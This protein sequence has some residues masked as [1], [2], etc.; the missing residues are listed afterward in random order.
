M[1]DY[2]DP[3]PRHKSLMTFKRYMKQYKKSQDNE[4]SGFFLNK[5]GT[6]SIAHDTSNHRGNTNKKK[7]LKEGILDK[8]KSAVGIKADHEKTLDQH[9]AE[10]NKEDHQE[11]LTKHSADL[12]KDWH[13]SRAAKYFK[14]A[15]MNIN[16]TLIDDH[17][18]G[19]SHEF[20]YD[21]YSAKM[22]KQ[23][24][25]EHEEDD[26]RSEAN[27]HHTILKH[28]KPLGKKMTLYH[29]SSHDFG[30]AA[31][32]SKKGIIHSPAHLSTSHDH[33]VS[34]GFGE[35]IVAIH[36]SEKD[37]AVHLDG[38]NAAHSH[39]SE[40]ETVIPAGTKLKHIKSHKT[41]D[42]YT[43]HHFKIHSQDDHEPF[44]KD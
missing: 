37:K 10:H 21:R 7:K 3:D 33:N 23:R 30:E 2:K 41:S 22:H 29:G 25:R 32:S 39:A 42:G 44:D 19:R 13:D 11:H 36:A 18:Q 27:V 26:W 24:R 14:A 16:H 38:E 28:A 12:H 8:V 1:S 6:V 4:K 9:A 20:T 40:K 15:S 43:I 34:K 5:D 17:K 35:H 31:K